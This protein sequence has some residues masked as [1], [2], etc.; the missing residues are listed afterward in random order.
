MRRC[1]ARTFTGAAACVAFMLVA[2]GADA[3][4][5][6]GDMRLEV[7]TLTP[8]TARVGQTAVRAH[9][10][11]RTDSVVVAVMDLRAVPGLWMV[12]NFQRQF[13]LSLAAGEEA[14]LEGHFELRRISPEATLR[15][16]IGPGEHA[17]DGNPVLRAI[18]YQETYEVGRHSPDVIDPADFFV[19][20][21]RGPL[22]IHAWKGSLAASRIDE[23]T[24]ERLAA[25][26]TVADLLAVQ[27]PGKIRLVFYAD[28]PTKIEQTGHRGIGWAFGTTLVEVYNE[29]VQLD[30]FH[31]LTH[32]VAAAAGYPPAFMN[33]G[34]A[35]YVAER[36]GADALRFLGAPG[37]RIDAVTC[38]LIDTQLYT[39]LEDL[40]ALDEIGSDAGRAGSQY[41]Q[42]GSFVKYLVQHG[43]LERFRRAYRTLTGDATAT[44]NRGRLAD[45]YGA[46]VETLQR[47]WLNS[48][49][50]EAPPRGP[51]ALSPA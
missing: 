15:V 47:G 10:R 27:P 44:A 8:D 2:R 9:I 24:D 33:E 26:A 20:A 41:A 38:N 51:A 32:I 34:F 18:G 13:A 17:D 3:Q 40:V 6:R 50:C 49:G 16:T 19:L 36:M 25:L 46:D 5:P 14:V 30:P 7:V 48:L 28:E 11:N 29:E 35:I 12:P 45:I 31:E 39:P 22:E 1:S 43:G 37:R 4:L 23:I 21:R 42:A